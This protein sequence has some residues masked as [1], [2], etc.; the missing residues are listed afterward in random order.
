MAQGEIVASTG[1]IAA[2]HNGFK[3]FAVYCQV[4][5]ET[6]VQK[7]LE[8]KGVAC[9][10]P[11]LETWSKR[12]DRRKRIEIP[13]FKGYLFVHVVLDAY[14]HLN[15]VK[16]PGALCFVRDSTGPLSVPNYQIQGLQIMLSA[17]QPLTIHS[18]LKEGE[19]VRVTRGPLAGCTGIL[20]RVNARRGRLIVNVDIFGKSV[21]VQLD[22]EDVEA[23][24]P[25]GESRL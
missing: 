23:A 11:M 1:Q 25:G 14:S 18:Y 9:F 17:A 7:V 21:S 5:H 6:K 12:L 22:I 19:R 8:N 10:L 2:L 16:T 4:N 20:D 15:V 13:M 3:W 24:T